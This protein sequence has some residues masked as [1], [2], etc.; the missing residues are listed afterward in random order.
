MNLNK[1]IRC[2][3]H[4]F[5]L[6]F[7]LLSLGLVYWQVV[8][9]PAITAGIHNQ[10][11]CL[12]QNAPL[13]GRILDRNGVVLAQSIPDKTATCG[14]IR[15]YSEPS[16]AGVIG[17]YVPEYGLV[18]G[19]EKQYSAI[20]DGVENHIPL[21]DLIN[22]TLHNHYIGN[23]IYLTIDVRIQRLVN[24][25]FTNY[26]PTTDALYRRPFFRGMAYESRRGAVI[27][28]N[29]QTGEI[30]AMVS[31]PGYDPNRMV[32][33]LAHGDLSYFNQI[34]HDTDQPLLMRPLNARYVPGSIFKTVTLLAALDT[35]I[36]TLDRPWSQ[37]EA[38]GPLVYDG[39]PILGDNLEYGI[40]TFHF[41]ITTT[42][43]YANS[44]NVVFAQLGVSIGR[45]KW[46]EYTHRFY[47]DQPVP[48]DLPAVQSSVQ[49]QDQR[50]LSTLQLAS[51]AFGQGV[52]DITPFQMSLID[53]AVANN[54]VLMRPML[55][56]KILDKDDNPVQISSPQVLSTVVSKATA[57]Q[58][59]Q[60]MYGVTTCGS[61]WRINKAFSY[62]DAIIGKTGTAE[63]GDGVA[64][65]G[66]MVTQA[67][68][69]LDNPD[70]MPNL[71]IVAM[72]ENAGEGAYV[73]GPAIWPMYRD[74]FRN[75]YVT[76]SLPPKNNP[77]QYCLQQGL[78]QTRS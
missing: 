40:Y 73:V 38:M 57:Y 11:R 12:L 55:V 39:W 28:S 8:A 71:T 26:H 13:R 29:P 77:Y 49:N 33:T 52:D 50:P 62:A 7:L 22:Q 44:D 78:W 76:T 20:L 2:V 64:P 70:Q 72:R 32:E 14:Y 24:K 4:I 5:L 6:L 65:H 67:P 58:V 9:A 31:T 61:S 59:R 27:V 69:W 36:T 18:G 75:G 15:Y 47:I 16:L 51:N 3:A 21:D 34:N 66:W 68:F 54:G 45:E 37:R 42:Y 74:I 46:L 48:F 19:I 43:A 56:A 10:R 35:G 1:G 63:I 53:N 17:Y 23:D 60:A 30:L 25:Y 41:P